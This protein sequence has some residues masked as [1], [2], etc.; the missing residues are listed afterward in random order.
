MYRTTILLKIPLIFRREYVMMDYKEIL[1]KI[2]LREEQI[3]EHLAFLRYFDENP[4][5]LHENILK[6]AVIRWGIRNSLLSWN[7]RLHDHHP[8]FYRYYDDQVLILSCHYKNIKQKRIRTAK[9]ESFF[10]F[11]F[12]LCLERLKYLHSIL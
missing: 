4:V 11:Q 10:Q 2:N 12:I 5:Y 1:N 6:Q 8:I 7:S 3:L 9:F